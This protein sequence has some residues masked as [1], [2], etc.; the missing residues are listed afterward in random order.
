MLLSP[1]LTLLSIV[2]NFCALLHVTNSRN[3]ISPRWPALDRAIYALEETTVTA[4]S[5]YL[6][7]VAPLPLTSSPVYSP[8]LRRA[9]W[10]YRS[11]AVRLLDLVDGSGKIQTAPD[12][13]SP[14]S[15]PLPLPSP[16]KPTDPITS[17]SLPTLTSLTYPATFEPFPTYDPSTPSVATSPVAQSSGLTWV[18]FCLVFA[19]MF[20]WLKVSRPHSSQ[21]PLSPNMP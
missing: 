7:I 18:A 1:T 4:Y 11:S 5:N 17:T 16:I 19:S 13:A 9:E 2:F 12:V 3:G 15:S 14:P 20:T 6:D 8:T 21:L 10:V